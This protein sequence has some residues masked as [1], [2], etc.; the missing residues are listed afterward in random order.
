MNEYD[1]E[2]TYELK[3]RLRWKYRQTDRR[4]NMKKET[5]SNV[6]QHTEMHV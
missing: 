1:C 6:L 3:N 2:Y 4:P 5:F